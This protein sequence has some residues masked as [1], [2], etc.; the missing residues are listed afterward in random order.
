VGGLY[1]TD[2]VTDEQSTD[3]V[4]TRIKQMVKKTVFFLEKKPERP[5]NFYGTGGM[6]IF[7]D[8]IYVMRGLMKEDHKFYKREGLYDDLPQRQ[9]KRILFMQLIG[10]LMRSPNIGKKVDGMMKEKILE[11]YD[12]LI[13]KVKA[14]E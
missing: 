3:D 8:L 1:L 7:R 5:R 10:S 6:K 9:I 14:E 2:I 4:L 11:P 13:K 12:K